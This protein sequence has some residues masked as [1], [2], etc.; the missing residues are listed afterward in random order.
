MSSKYSKIQISSY[1]L[2][3]YCFLLVLLVLVAYERVIPKLFVQPQQTFHQFLLILVKIF[4]TTNQN[5]FW[6]TFQMFLHQWIDHTRL[7]LQQKFF[8]MVCPLDFQQ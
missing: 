1:I 7:L 3:G 6:Q 8:Y 5:F 2:I 4:V